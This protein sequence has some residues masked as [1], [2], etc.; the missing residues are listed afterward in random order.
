L[1][2]IAIAGLAQLRRRNLQ[3]PPGLVYEEEEPGRIFEGFKLSEGQAAE[4]CYADSRPY[5]PVA[6]LSGSNNILAL[7]EATRVVARRDVL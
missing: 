6:Q 1:I 7:N 4:T 5:G 3:A 2:I